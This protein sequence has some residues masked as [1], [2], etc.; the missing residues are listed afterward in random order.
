MMNRVAQTRAG[1]STVHWLT[2]EQVD[3][4]QKCR[5]LTHTSIVPCGDTKG[6]P[7]LGGFMLVGGACDSLPPY[8][9]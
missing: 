6:I 4:S 5:D 3:R 9:T 8:W 1:G 2:T 7:G